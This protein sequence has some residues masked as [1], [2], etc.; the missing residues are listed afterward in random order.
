MPIS[1]MQ[2]KHAATARD[3]TPIAGASGDTFFISPVLAGLGREERTR[4]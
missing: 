3:G 4:V 2:A 1:V